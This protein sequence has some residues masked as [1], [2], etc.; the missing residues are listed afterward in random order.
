MIVPLARYEQLGEL[1]EIA[2]LLEAGD[3]RALYLEEHPSSELDPFVV[4]GSMSQ[5]QQKLGLGAIISEVAHRS[6][7]LIAKLLAGVDVCSGGR[8]LV[9]I[10]ELD[11]DNGEHAMLSEALLFVHTMVSQDSTTMQGEYF[12]VEDAWNTPRYII[13]TSHF[14]KTSYALGAREL[15]RHIEL[16]N[17]LSSALLV[18]LSVCSDEEMA[19]IERF[20]HT[21]SVLSPVVGVLDVEE[22]F[23]SSTL[24][25]IMRPQVF[26][27]WLF[28]WREQP[29]LS[30]IQ[31]L[32]TQ[33]AHASF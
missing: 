17:D 14:P 24:F 23:E 8:G 30:E 11:V 25:S 27:G 21:R 1:R 33:L 6:P 29:P 22:G 10:G 9:C 2:S 7:S 32:L 28:R 31:L 16:G 26:D 4:L 20:V 12:R 15:V 19:T 5:A 3:A 18:E 13:E